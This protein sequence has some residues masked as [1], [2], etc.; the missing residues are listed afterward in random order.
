[1]ALLTIIILLVVLWA[2]R[3]GR[4]KV[5]L[6]PDEARTIRERWWWRAWVELKSW[7]L[8]FA[9]G[10]ALAADTFARAHWH[11]SIYA[12][13]VW[14]SLL[15]FSRLAIWVTLAGVAVLFAVGSVAKVLLNQ[16]IQSPP[17]LGPLIIAVVFAIIIRAV[18]FL[19]LRQAGTTISKP[20]P[21]SSPEP[22]E[23]SVKHLT[24]E[25]E[26]DTDTW[27][28]ENGNREPA[29]IKYPKYEDRPENHNRL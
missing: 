7:V 25:H 9:F 26:W 11:W 16:A 10:Y 29:N 22:R 21:G 17:F 19:S 13:I 4:L 8:C 27:R 12:L 5:V 15:L 24:P 3:N 23:A 18:F 14:F 6:T 1:M 2:S 28:Y 20:Q